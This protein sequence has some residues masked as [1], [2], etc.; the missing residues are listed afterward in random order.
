MA[1]VIEKHVRRVMHVQ[2][3]KLVAKSIAEE[4][5]AGY[6]EGYLAVWDNVDY[7]N[8]VMV[9]GCFSRS[10]KQVVAARKVKLMSKH[11]AHGGDAPECIGTI[12]EAKEDDHGLWI[13]AEF[14]SAADAQNIR[15]KVVEKHINGLSVGFYAIDWEERSEKR[16]DEIVS[17]VYHKECRLAEG[18]VTVKPV[19]DLA[20]VTAAK[21]D[22]PNAAPVTG[23]DEPV[24]TAKAPGGTSSTPLDTTRMK[25]LNEQM[26]MR[27]VMH[28]TSIKN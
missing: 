24:T 6:L 19:N 5:G 2:D 17:I 25:S 1:A 10:I 27:L 14:S 4:P 9:K 26:R 16:G 23:K 15:T 18:T 22:S 28:R 13:R 7:Q 20:E 12:V 3:A 11:F 21:S 8:E